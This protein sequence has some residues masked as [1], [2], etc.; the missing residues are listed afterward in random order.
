[1]SRASD[2]MSP[3]TLEAGLTGGGASIDNGLSL[4]LTDTGDESRDSAS[5]MSK[6]IERGT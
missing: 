5:N 2:S 3:S 4:C 1:M 6:G